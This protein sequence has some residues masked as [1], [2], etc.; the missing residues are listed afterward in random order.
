MDI[1]W[2]AIRIAE[3]DEAE[4]ATAALRL[5]IE[6]VFTEDD[7]YRSSDESL[8]QGLSSMSSS[9]SSSFEEE[10]VGSEGSS[11]F[12]SSELFPGRLSP[13]PE[14]EDEDDESDA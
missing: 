8:T 11:S 1:A 7:D 6:P 9:S 12:I 2:L 4:A 13:I 14:E 10:S 5:Q 3:Q